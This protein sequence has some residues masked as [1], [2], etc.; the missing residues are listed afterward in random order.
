M[1]EAHQAAA[2]QGSPQA[3][4]ATVTLGSLAR[5]IILELAHDGL[6]LTYK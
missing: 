5:N 6:A 2:I 4:N 1:R 3:R